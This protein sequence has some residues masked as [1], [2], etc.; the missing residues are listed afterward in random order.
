MRQ[1]V[2]I[3]ALIVIG[4][5]GVTSKATMAQD[6]LVPQIL[7]SQPQLQEVVTL[8]ANFRLQIVLGLVEE[9]AD[10]NRVLR[11][12]TYRAGAEYFYPAST[13]KLFAAIAAAQ[14]LAAIREETGYA[15]ALDTPMMVHPLFE[16]DEL[17]MDDLDNLEGGFK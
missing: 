5:S 16:D 3:V 11:Q 4:I 2:W 9:G 1:L 17:E 15:I 14:K 6:N 13:V 8:S 12:H 10:G 7:D